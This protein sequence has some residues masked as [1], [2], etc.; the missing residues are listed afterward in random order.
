MPVATPRALAQ[1][2]PFAVLV[3]REDVDEVGPVWF[4]ASI[5]TGHTTHGDSAEDAIEA[6]GRTLELAV[7]FAAEHGAAPREWFAR[8][9]PCEPARVEAF[10]SLAASGRVVSRTCPSCVL[11]LHVA[12]REV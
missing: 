3:Y 11:A 10:R 12:V 7:A 1:V 4:A 8:Q 2:F 6:I 5:F 9:R